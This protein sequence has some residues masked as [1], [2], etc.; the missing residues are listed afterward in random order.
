MAQDKKPNKKPGAPTKY[1]PS[2]CEKVLQ[3]IGGGRDVLEFSKEIGVTRKTIYNWRDKHPEFCEALKKALEYSEATW[4]SKLQEMMFDKNVNP[5]LAKL[6]FANRFGWSDKVSTDHTSS[7][8]SMS[9]KP[10]YIE[11]SDKKEMEKHISEVVDA[12]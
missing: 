1:D 12:D 3:F 6:Y 7:D 4:M 11:V 5:A 10:I 2:Y 8:N 9:Q